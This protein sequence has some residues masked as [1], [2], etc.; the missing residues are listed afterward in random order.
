MQDLFQAVNVH[1]ISVV[2]FF[3]TAITK[4][5][6]A[7]SSFNV[8]LSTQNDAILGPYSVQKYYQLTQQLKAKI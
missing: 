7:I 1:Q 4:T 6:Q 2:T 8:A 5:Q 3:I